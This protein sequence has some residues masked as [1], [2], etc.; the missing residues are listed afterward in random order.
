KP[1][2]VTQDSE[3]EQGPEDLKDSKKHAKQKPMK[4]PER[5]VVKD[6]AEDST[7]AASDMLRKY[8]NR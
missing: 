7:A 6:E 4:L 2:E 8:F 1:A 3:E 5:I